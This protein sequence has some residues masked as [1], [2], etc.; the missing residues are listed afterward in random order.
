M[1]ISILIPA[2][3]SSETIGNCLD[4]IFKNKM[5]QVEV[6][7]L[8][9]GSKDNL[10]EALRPYRNRINYYEHQQN[11]G[12]AK[13]RNDLIEKA[14]G[15]YFLFIDSDDQI[16][17]DL[18]KTLKENIDNEDILAFQIEEISKENKVVRTKPVGKKISG[19]DFLNKCIE[20]KTTFDTPVAYLYRKAYFKEQNFKYEEGHRHE[21]FGL[22]PI[23]LLNAK[24]VTSLDYVGYSYI[25]SDNSE[26]RGDTKRR[27]ENAYDMLYHYDHLK[28]TIDQSTWIKEETRNYFHSFLA[29][30]LL[31]R[32]TSLDKKDQKDYVK[33][34]KSR[35]IASLLLSDNS[36]R[37]IKKMLISIRYQNAKYFM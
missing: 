15:D 29:N 22:T 14:T 12:T 9:D 11:E 21:D 27:K 34:L 5:N 18:I 36:K 20:T 26:T 30:S 35:K 23:V 2:Y 28:K 4:S 33:E 8:N 13:T 24:S 6:I 31:S 37:K 17:E 32:I 19:E 1:K 25:Q 16:K 10:E 7:I 3:E